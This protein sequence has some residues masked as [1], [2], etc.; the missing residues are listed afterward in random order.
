MAKH[1]ELTQPYLQELF[2]EM[3]LSFTAAQME[4]F[5]RYDDFLIDYNRKTN[6]TRITEPCDVAVKHFGDSLSLLLEDVLPTGATVVDVGTG[7]GFPG[8]PLA[9]A[10]PDLRVTLM[11]SLRKRIVFLE[12]LIKLLGITNVDVVW[13]RAEDLGHNSKY[14]GQ[15]DVV[16]ARAVASLKVLV[17]LCLPFAKTGGCFLAMKGPKAEVEVADAANALKI[18]G[19]K[20]NAI[21]AITLPILNESRS[22]VSIGKIVSTTR[23]YP[24]KAGIPERQPL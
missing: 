7:A 3:G 16:I 21:T 19:A 1:S 10:R 15:F 14:R 17:E 6:L 24:R 22:L 9:I 20:V 5:S 18:L 2:A 4:L 13:G 23:S 11:D 8:I 12:E